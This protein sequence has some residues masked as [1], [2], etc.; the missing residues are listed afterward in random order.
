MLN[1]SKTYNNKIL[2]E[3]QHNILST[4]I[5]EFIL[6]AEPVGS[7]TISKKANIGLSPAT[8]RN[9]MSDLEETGFLEQPHTSAGR[10][11][12][13]K[14]YRY[15][16]NFLMKQ[17]EL[18]DQE[19][20]TIE[21]YMVHASEVDE[22]LELASRALG[23]VTHQLGIALSPRFEKGIFKKIEFVQLSSSRI[24]LVL[25]LK[26][27]IAKTMTVEINTQI[28]PEKL[29]AICS[30]LNERFSERSIADIRKT[31]KESVFGINEG[32]NMGVIRLFIP[33]V[34]QLFSNSMCLNLHTSGI[35]VVLSQPE[36]LNKSMIETIVELL[37]NKNTLIH[38]LSEREK[39]QGAC[40]TI[41]G[42]NQNGEFKS[43]SIV[44]SNYSIGAMKGTLGVIGPTRMPYPKLVSAIDYTVK[45]LEEK[46]KMLNAGIH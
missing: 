27:G 2:H 16:V 20:N 38:L 10:I 8:I 26:S 44:T 22:V 23:K 21:S 18:T 24:L 13:D 17:E 34:E 37:E 14:G 43:F 15:Y 28:D 31:I 39:K 6:T 45:T 42:E 19:K 11:P 12:T 7:R 3:R 5:Q 41:G 35:P 9:V 33:S 29:Y 25:A 40:I 30:V 36:F 1:N 46:H 4:V 32:S